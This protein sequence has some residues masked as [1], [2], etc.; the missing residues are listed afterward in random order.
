MT[1]FTRRHFIAAATAPLAL[2][3]CGNGVGTDGARRV[4]GR[5]AE[6]FDFMYRTLPETQDFA[7]RAAGVRMM[8]VVTKAGFGLGGS[9][10][11][12]ALLVDGVTVDYY[13]ATSAS[14]GLQI[15]G[16]QS[17]HAIF[18]MTQ[19]APRNFRTSPGWVAGADVEYVA[20]NE[21]LTLSLDTTELLT[22][23]VAVA[24]GQAGLLAGASL[25]GL[26]YSRIIP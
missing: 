14:I 9:Y 12:G 11:R 1:A 5:V 6:A 24:F 18:F 21:S 4:D 17:S 26:K 25:E 10:G 19:P 13:S 3:A 8:P 23:V 22:P 16:Q 2:A 15:G 7:A 20:A